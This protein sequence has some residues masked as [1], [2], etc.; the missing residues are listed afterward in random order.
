[1]E[2]IKVKLTKE[3]SKAVFEKMI[4]ESQRGFNNEMKRGEKLDPEGVEGYAYLYV[5]HAGDSYFVGWSGD[6]SGGYKGTCYED[7]TYTELTANEY[8]EISF[9]MVSVEGA[10]APKKRHATLEEA[11][12]GA[13]RLANQG[14]GKVVHVLEI[15]KTYKSRL[16]VEE[17]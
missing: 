6:Y 8:L 7:H 13:I 2:N 4:S 3:T 1:M 10:R 15:K 11:E 9:F 12:A 5:T 14:K 17:V 16:V